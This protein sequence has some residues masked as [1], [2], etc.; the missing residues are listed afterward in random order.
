MKDSDVELSKWKQE[1]EKGRV[2]FVIHTSF[3]AILGVMIGRSIEPVLLSDEAWS[4]TQTTDILTSGLWASAGAIP[5]SF[6]NQ[7][8]IAFARK[9]LNTIRVFPR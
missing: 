4:W 1:R 5:V 7:E 6:I 9:T 8:N 3:P 2:W